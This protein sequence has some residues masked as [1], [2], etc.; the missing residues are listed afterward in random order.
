MK[1]K[2]VSTKK[3]IATIIILIIIIIGMFISNNAKKTY[4]GRDNLKGKLL[5]GSD[6]PDDDVNKC[7]GTNADGSVT[8]T[9]TGVTIPDSCNPAGGLTNAFCVDGSIVQFGQAC[10]NGC[11]NGAC[12]FPEPP[13]QI[14]DI[15]GDSYVGMSDLQALTDNWLE[16]CKPNFPDNPPCSPEGDDS[17]GGADLNGDGC[18]N[19]QDFAILTDNWSPPPDDSTPDKS[20]PPINN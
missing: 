12:I 18:V 10:E 14:G 5:T 9:N 17:C 13:S 4:F 19:M 3:L 20:P 6:T 11:Q 8:D 7:S 1:K 15:D 16:G 2:R